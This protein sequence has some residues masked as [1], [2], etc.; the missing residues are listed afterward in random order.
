MKFYISF[1][2]VHVHSINGKTVD[3]DCLVELEAATH[4]RAH[5]AAMSIFRGVF[6]RVYS[7]VPDMKFFPRGVIKL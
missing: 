6:H 4:G 3:K 1:G 7:K 5:E 2:Q